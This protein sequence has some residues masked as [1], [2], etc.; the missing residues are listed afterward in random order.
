MHKIKLDLVGA[1]FRVSSVCHACAVEFVHVDSEAHGDEARCA[2]FVGGQ[3][4]RS[5]R[6]N[7][8]LRVCAWGERLR[9]PAR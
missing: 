6:P 4:E 1:V 3:L 8:A 2:W 7:L 5:Y 9:V